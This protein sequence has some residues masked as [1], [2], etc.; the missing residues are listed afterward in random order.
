VTVTAWLNTATADAERR[1]L[2][3]LRLLIENLARTVSALR[4]ADWNEDASGARHEPTP[5][6]DAR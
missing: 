3:A 1:G 6:P 2:P 5:R 4:S